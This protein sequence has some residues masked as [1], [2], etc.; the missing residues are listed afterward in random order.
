MTDR[1]A[2]MLTM[3]ALKAR[4]DDELSN[5]P[6]AAACLA[7]ERHQ[8]T[9]VGH[10]LEALD[11]VAYPVRVLAVDDAGRERA[12]LL[13]H[14]VKRHRIQRVATLTPHRLHLARS[15]PE[16]RLHAA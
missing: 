2:M 12:E 7:Q 16:E 5:N 9:H 14:L 4:P 8:P 1:G 13:V 10:A 11:V 3:L 15:V 6:D